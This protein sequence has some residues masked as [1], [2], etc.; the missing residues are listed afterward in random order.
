M[1]TIVHGMNHSSPIPQL[2]SPEDDA[3]PFE[4]PGVRGLNHEVFMR[5]LPM[6]W[7][8]ANTLG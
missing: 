4:P 7:S 8:A 1:K 2:V 3:R 6:A 5:I